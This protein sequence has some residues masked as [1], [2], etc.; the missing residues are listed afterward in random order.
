MA[1]DAA[2]GTAVLF[3]GAIGTPRCNSSSGML[4]A[5]TWTWG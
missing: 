3:G 1:Y 4:V 2:T 5:Q